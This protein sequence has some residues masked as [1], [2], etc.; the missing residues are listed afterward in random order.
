MYDLNNAVDVPWDDY[1]A[2]K[3]VLDAD[4]AARTGRFDWKLNAWGLDEHVGWAMWER[5]SHYYFRVRV[6]LAHAMTI[7]LTSHVVPTLLLNAWRVQVRA[8]IMRCSLACVERLNHSSFWLLQAKWGPMVDPAEICRIEVKSAATG[9][10]SLPQQ[11][12]G[13]LDSLQRRNWIEE[14]RV[15]PWAGCAEGD[16]GLPQQQQGIRCLPG[17]RQD[18][19]GRLC[20]PLT[21]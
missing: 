8:G 16:A 3:A 20:G 5:S 19:G 18:W 10:E 2:A 11:P 14:D 13:N 1:E 17:E 21:S 12:F 6:L 4:E 9:E 7:S 15:I